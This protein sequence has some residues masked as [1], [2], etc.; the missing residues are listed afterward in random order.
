MQAINTALRDPTS[1]SRSR[2]AR[3]LQAHFMQKETKV[4][5]GY[6]SVQGPEVNSNPVPWTCL[7][8]PFSKTCW[9]KRFITWVACHPVPRLTGLL[10]ALFFKMQGK[11]WDIC[12][13]SLTLFCYPIVLTVWQLS[14]SVDQ[15]HV[16]CKMK[17]T[18]QPDSDSSTAT[19][20]PL[21]SPWGVKVT[22][23]RLTFSIFETEIEI[24][25]RDWLLRILKENLSLRYR[26]LVRAA[27]SPGCL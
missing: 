13:I 15:S 25:L 9:Q 17:S 21:L 11:T 20:C 12:P 19:W 26:T 2:Q 18:A 8:P 5:C 27:G 16:S 7:H 6:T 22:S 23:Q 1:T 4:L 10:E 3:N 14:N 24:S